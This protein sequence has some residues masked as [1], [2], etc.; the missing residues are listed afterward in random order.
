MV[1]GNVPILGRICCSPGRVCGHL[2]GVDDQGF[3]E[4]LTLGKPHETLPKILS[5]YLGHIFTS[6][7][8]L[9]RGSLALNHDLDPYHFNGWRWVKHSSSNFYSLFPNA[10]FLS[11][12]C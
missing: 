2:R 4:N 8:L 7:V 1:V 10:I 5:P 3:D 6:C 12:G 9:E 11:T